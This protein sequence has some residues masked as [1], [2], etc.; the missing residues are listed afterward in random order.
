MTEKNKVIVVTGAS[1]GIGAATVR[2]LVASGANVVFGARRQSKLDDL[3]AGLPDTHIAYTVTDVSKHD[4]MCRLANLAL[5]R[6]GRIDVLFNNAGIMPLSTLTE[7][8]R[9][10]WQSMIQ[11]NVIGL[12]NGISAVLPIMHQ[13]GYG[14]IIA[15]GSMAG[16]NI[17]PNSAVYCASKFAERAIMEGLRQEELSNHIK[18]TY[19]APG[20]VKTELT[21]S[22]GNVTHEA[23]IQK[24]W[25]E[26]NNSL[27]A[28][29]LAEMVEYI[30]DTPATVAI[31]EVKIRPRA[32]R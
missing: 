19:L 12:L 27:S 1:S 31:N 24:A 8:Q 11:I 22:I 2:R 3:A 9:D 15:T 32:E 6:F 16:Y 17:Y 28:D 26:P 20:M 23:E 18:T 25:Q 5:A 29:N 30:I 14:H 13:Q 7:N 10:D 4:D 21:R